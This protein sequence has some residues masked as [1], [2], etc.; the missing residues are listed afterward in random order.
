MAFPPN[1][2]QFTNGFRLIAGDALNNIFSG[3]WAITPAIA[4]GNGGST[5]NPEG[6]LSANLTSTGTAAGTAEQTL[7][8]F[9][10]PA[11]TLSA[12]KKGVKIKAWGVTAA[13]ANN[14]TMKLYFGAAV[15]TTL[16]AATN[17]KGWELELEVYKTG[18]STQVVFGKGQVDTTNVTALVTTGT[19]TDT[20]AIVIKVTGTDGTDSAGDI[21]AKGLTVEMVN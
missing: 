7:L 12:A 5:I 19:E 21:V 20:A 2:T 1:Y 8:T 6:L 9:S 17:N 10:L 14:K 16:T 11:K 13:N 15:I 18:S 4:A 3:R